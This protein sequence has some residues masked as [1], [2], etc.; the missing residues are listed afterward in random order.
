LA[1][2]GV[3]ATVVDA[4]FVKPLDAR[5]L[6]DAARRCGRMVT[7]EDHA[8]IGGLGSAVLE[9]LS[10]A[11]PGTRVRALGVGDAF[12]DHAEVAEQ[13]TN[14]EIDAPSVVQAAR[15]LLGGMA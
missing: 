15:E 3:S 6:A 8:A 10:A 5:V 4:R 14:A 9:C 1:E 12:V 13:W 11:A 7:V 2:I